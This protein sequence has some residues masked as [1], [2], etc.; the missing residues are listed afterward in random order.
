MANAIPMPIMGS[1]LSI[2]LTEFGYEKQIIGVFALFSLPMSFKVL[3]MVLIDYYPHRKGWLLF[4]LTGCSLSLMSLSFIDPM[5]SPIK[6]AFALLGLSTFTGGVYMAGIPY[7]LESLETSQ[8]PVGSAN[9]VAGYRIGLFCGGAGT[10]FLSTV[11]DWSSAFRLMALLLAIGSVYISFLP[12]PFK[13]KLAQHPSFFSMFSEPIRAFWNKSDRMLVLWLLL[14]FKFGD[15]LIKYMGGPFY[16]D[17]GFTKTDLVSAAKTWGMVSTLLGAFAGG[18]L[19]KGK[20]NTMNVI[21]LGF[22][23]AFTLFCYYGM[24]FIGKSLP[25]LYLTVALD[26]FTGG[27]LM[28]SFIAFLWKQCDKT[29]ASMQYALFWSFIS[30]KTDLVACLGGIIA[31]YCDWST[32]F[33]IAATLATLTSLFPLLFVRSLI[34]DKQTNWV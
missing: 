10:L 33:L 8:Y 26:H 11:L 15:E 31:E 18:V 30:F 25:A 20:H 32:F 17:L 13:S 19:L 23:H 27:L 29:Y 14:L 24:S 2:W 5:A 34:K 12:V 1:V 7:E 21:R 6:L 4:M 22:L 9:I 28:T 3:W 16:L